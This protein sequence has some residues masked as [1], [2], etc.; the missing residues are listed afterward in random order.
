MIQI[1]SFSKDNQNR[2]FSYYKELYIVKPSKEI[3]TNTKIKKKKVRVLLIQ[4]NAIKINKFNLN[5]K[6]L[7]ID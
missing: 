2:K 6:R 5:T 3:K 4:H 1:F 7:Y